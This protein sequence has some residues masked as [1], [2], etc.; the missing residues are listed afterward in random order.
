MLVGD[1]TDLLVLALHVCN[2]SDIHQKI[3]IMRPSSDSFIDTQTIL[4]SHPKQVID[5]ILPIHALSG[6]D[7]V[8]ALFG[9]GKTKLVQSIRKQL[10]LVD[11]LAVFFFTAQCPETKTH[12]MWK[13]DPGID[14]H[15]AIKEN[16]SI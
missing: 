11:N 14:V 8:S 2:T 6:C 15:A 4:K 16:Y 12:R 5:N 1:D 10:N 13:A 7:T 3:L 9:I